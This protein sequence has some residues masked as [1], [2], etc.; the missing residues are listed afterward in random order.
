MCG[1]L[2]AL[3][4]IT[5]NEL[6]RNYVKLT[7]ST[8]N[9]PA[10][11]RERGLWQHK[12]NKLSLKM[13]TYSGSRFANCDDMGTQPGFIVLPNGETGRVNLV[14]Y[15]NSKCGLVVQSVVADESYAFADCIDAAKAI[16]HDLQLIMNHGIPLTILTDSEILFKF[17]L[18]FT[19]TTKKRLMID[20]K[21]SR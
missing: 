6:E 1:T 7:N 16:K 8:I 10:T 11:K 5:A 21:V 15:S 12:L 13:V 3:S 19:V 17:L 14:I 4:K 2:T 9:G 18:K 20:F